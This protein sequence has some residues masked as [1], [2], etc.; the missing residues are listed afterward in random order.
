MGYLEKLERNRQDFIVL[1]TRG[2][3]IRQ[4]GDPTFSGGKTVV[5]D[6]EAGECPECDQE[7]AQAQFLMGRLGTPKGEPNE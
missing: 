4:T 1:C 7:I 5:I 3:F 2:H 6:Q